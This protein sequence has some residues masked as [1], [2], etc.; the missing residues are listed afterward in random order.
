MNSARPGFTLIELLGVVA[1]IIILSTLTFTIFKVVQR[2]ADTNRTRQILAVLRIGLNQAKADGR[3]LRPVA[4]PLAAADPV[5]ALPS[6]GVGAF[7]QDNPWPVHGMPLAKCRLL[8]SQGSQNEAV[9]NWLLGSSGTLAELSHLHSLYQFVPN[10][11]DSRSHQATWPMPSWG[12]G[13]IPNPMPTGYGYDRMNQDRNWAAGSLYGMYFYDA[14]GTEILV[15]PSTAS[16]EV[17]LLSAGP[18]TSGDP[19]PYFGHPTGSAKDVKRWADN[20]IDGDP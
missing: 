20:I 5:S 16:D 13:A 17:T 15:Y 12:S 2:H 3:S 4:H 9:L 18:L 7:V 11:Y 1:I 10:A 8:V 14:W 6:G 19:F